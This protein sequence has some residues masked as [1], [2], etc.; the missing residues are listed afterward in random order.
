[1]LR[2][3]LVTRLRRALIVVGKAPQAGKTKTRLVPPLSAEAA[4]ELYRGFLLDA[5][6]LGLGL[7]WERVTVVH[8]RGA[9]ADLRPLLPATVCLLEQTAAGLGDALA[10]AFDHHFRERFDR[11]VL[12][13]S[14]NPTLT[15]QPIREACAALD[16]GR[17][18]SIGPSVDGGYYL[19]GLRAPHLG[20]FEHVEWSTP[21]VYAQTLAQA[22]SLGLRTHSVAEW[23]DVDEPADLLRLQR[24]LRTRPLEIAPHTRAALERLRASGMLS[25]LWDE[26]RRLAARSRSVHTSNALAD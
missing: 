2:C 1:V 12:I 5:V 20:V 14:D 8:P 17:D 23:Y 19:I 9:G 24:E 4:A 15:E 25:D 18:L 6:E 21:R 3:R 11:V 22:R 7:G 10:S 26:Q 16:D 13:G